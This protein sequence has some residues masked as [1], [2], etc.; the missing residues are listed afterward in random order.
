M[1]KSYRTLLSVI[2]EI[3]FCWSLILSLSPSPSLSFPLS[4]FLSLSFS[5]FLIL[6]VYNIIV[7]FFNFYLPV[8]IAIEH[9][10]TVTSQNNKVIFAFIKAQ[11]NVKKWFVLYTWLCEWWTRLKL[12]FY[13]STSICQFIKIMHIARN[14]NLIR[15]IINLLITE[16]SNLKKKKVIWS[17]WISSV[18]NFWIGSCHMER[19][20]F[21]VHWFGE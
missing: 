20:L 1:D 13:P 19:F 5:L 10:E 12:I 11:I 7:V 3:H 9:I 4:L 2:I 14:T 18:L 8:Q 21:G 15:P 6:F 17:Q 16:W